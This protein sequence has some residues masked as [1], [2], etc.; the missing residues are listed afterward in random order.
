MTVN[1]V[2]NGIL[3]TLTGEQLKRLNDLRS[4]HQESYENPDRMIMTEFDGVI[5]SAYRL[6]QVLDQ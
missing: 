6:E 1:I 2:S 4:S 3:I 5:A